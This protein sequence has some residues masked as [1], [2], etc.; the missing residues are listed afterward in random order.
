MNK[1]Q[2]IINSMSLEDLEKL[3]KDLYQGNL[4]KLIDKRLTASS[5][6]LCPVCG[7]KILHNNYKL[8]FGKDYLRRQVSFDG[9][10]CLV[11]FVNSRIKKYESKRH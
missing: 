4:H 11:Y 10:D 2:E 1:L 5:D 3:K 8:E 6:K 9:L 7:E